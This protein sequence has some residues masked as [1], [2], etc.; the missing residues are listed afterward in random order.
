M[1]G[2]H[3]F[4]DSDLH[5]RR[6]AA[7]VEELIPWLDV[8]YRTITDSKARLLLGEE[9]GG[10]AAL[11]LLLD[12]PE[13]FSKSWALSPEAVAFEAIGCLDLASDGNAYTEVDD[14]Q[15]PA[16]R[17][18]LSDEREI[19]HLDV[20]DEVMLCR[21]LR[22][23]GMSGQKWDELRAA[24]GA[25]QAGQIGPRWPF[26]PETGRMRPE[27]VMRW[28]SRDLTTRVRNEPR[29]AKRLVEDARIFVGAY[30]ERYR[31]LGVRFLEMT[32]EAVLAEHDRD[33]DWVV[34]IEE[35][36][37]ES[38]NAIARLPVHDE[39]IT[40]LRNNAFHD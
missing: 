1:F 20:E 26:D 3:F 18:V 37:S 17:T 25:V 2:H 21:T 24:F 35:A 19:V 13:V 38:S 5:G 33:L 28:M 14:S 27:E 23:N 12:H 4:I 31:N 22:S 34:E 7:L 11:T 10:R 30:D 29:V 15:R 36:D 40:T 8:R 6:S 39:I 32:T 16:M 9:Q